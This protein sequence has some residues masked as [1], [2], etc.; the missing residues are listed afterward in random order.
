MSIK[1]LPAPPHFRAAEKA[2]WDYHTGN[3]FSLQLAAAAWISRYSLKS[4]SRDRKRVHLLVMDQQHDFCCPQGSLYVGGRSGTGA[5]DDSVRLAEF[6]YHYLHVISEVTCTMDSHLPY[7]VFFPS[8]H[9]SNNRRHP[10]PFTVI[11]E[12][13]YR[14]GQYRA[15]PLMA[16]HLGVTQAWLNHQFT[17]YCAQLKQSG[18]YDL[19][20]WPY[21]CLI[22]HHGHKLVG[23]IDEARLFHSFARGAANVPAIKG[24]NPLTEHY[25]IFQPEV[26]TTWDGNA[27][28]SVK[29][30]TALLDTLLRSDYVVIGGEAASHC[31]AWSVKDLLK[32]IRGADPKLAQKVY[33]LQ[34]CT[35][36]VVVRDTAGAVLV[37]YTREQ[38]KAFDEFQ[39]AGMHLVKSTDPIDTWPDIQ[40]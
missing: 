7:Q 38:V 6:I 23:L 25:S 39:R 14:S 28:P 4:V 1:A 30:N 26:L 12:E 35:S 31:L 24:D 36:P 19:T 13:D 9:V 34:D 20:I 22:G 21:H 8:A 37:D 32:H 17:W 3:V 2:Q 16:A 33:I 27:I 40:L 29:K 18:K 15:N 5:A 11:R 10:E